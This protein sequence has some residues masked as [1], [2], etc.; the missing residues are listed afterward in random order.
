MGFGAK[1]ARTM[2]CTPPQIWKQADLSILV[3]AASIGSSISS[4]GG[5]KAWETRL[6]Q[7][8]QELDDMYSLVITIQERVG[9]LAS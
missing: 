4:S 9:K 6:L 2:V 1:F 5:R 3:Q 8:Q 7:L